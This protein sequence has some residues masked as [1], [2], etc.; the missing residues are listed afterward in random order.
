MKPLLTLAIVVLLSSQAAHVTA[1]SK[2]VAPLGYIEFTTTR[3]VLGMPKDRTI[4]LLSERYEV[5]T[6]NCVVGVKD[7][8]AVSEKTGPPLHGWRPEFRE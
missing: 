2:L 6:C 8:W 1:Q 3:L 4:A 5:T 7:A